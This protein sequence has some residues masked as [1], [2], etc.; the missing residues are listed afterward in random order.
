MTAASTFM[1]MSSCSAPPGE[2]PVPEVTGDV[3]ERRVEPLR[4]VCIEQAE[5]GE[6]GDVDAAGRDVVG[7]QR[8]VDLERVAQRERGIGC[9]GGEAAV[10]QGGLARGLVIG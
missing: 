1:W 8:Q 4:V 6:L 3:V 2:G 10:P 7:R 9:G 5:P